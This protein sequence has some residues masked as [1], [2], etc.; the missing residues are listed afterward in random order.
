MTPK[1]QLDSDKIFFQKIKQLRKLPRVDFIVA[2]DLYTRL[3][4]SR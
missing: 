3:K 1:F 4:I 2:P